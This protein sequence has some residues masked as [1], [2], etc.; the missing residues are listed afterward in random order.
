MAN[1]FLRVCS[2]SETGLCRR[3]SSM[4]RRRR[5]RRRRR[6]Y[7]HRRGGREV[8]LS[9]Q[10][11]FADAS[12][13]CV[14]EGCASRYGLLQHRCQR[15][16]A[17]RG[18]KWHSATRHLS[19][20]NLEG[21]CRPRQCPN[22]HSHGTPVGA[23]TAGGAGAGGWSADA[24]TMNSSPPPAL[25]SLG[26]PHSSSSH[27]YAFPLLVLPVF[28]LFVRRGSKCDGKYQCHYSRREGSASGCGDSAEGKLSRS[29]PS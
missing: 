26:E 1:A 4:L 17:L 11:G 29:G 16:I 13:G 21:E 23:A 9:G 27:L 8:R 28:I 22:G 15:R 19:K 3:S 20:P 12:G 25:P 10:A 14:G 24:V 6:S 2:E 5:R 18:N 7:H